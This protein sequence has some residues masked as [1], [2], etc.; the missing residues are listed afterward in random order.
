MKLL[1][2]VFFFMVILFWICLILG[3]MLE[4]GIEEVFG[5]I[6]LDI[7]GLDVWSYM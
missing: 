3:E 2:K 1:F 7:F 5:F 4:D 6:M